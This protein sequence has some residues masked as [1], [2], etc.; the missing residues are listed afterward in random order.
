MALNILEIFLEPLI[1]MFDNGT[2]PKDIEAVLSRYGLKTIE[3]MPTMGNMVRASCPKGK[4]HDLIKAIEHDKPAH[5]FS[6]NY[7]LILTNMDNEYS[8]TI[9]HPTR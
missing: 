7:N 1:L 6:V 8:V 2:T 9:D 5:L 4:E 3:A